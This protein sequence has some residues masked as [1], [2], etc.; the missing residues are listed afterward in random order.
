MINLHTD[1]LGKRYRRRVLFR[2]LSFEVSGG[3]VAAVTGPNGSGKSTLLRI[4]AGVLTPDTGSVAL[5]EGP[6]AVPPDRHSLRVGLVAPYL[7]LYDTLSARENLR[8]IA[9]VRGLNGAETRITEMLHLVNLENRSDDLLGT[10]SSGM[11]QRMKYAA[12]LLASPLLLLLDEPSAN[13][14]EAG[15][16]MVSRVID[17]QI[18]LSR[19]VIVATNDPA[20]AARAA[21]RIDLTRFVV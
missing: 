4:L 16:H 2:D 13:L 6:V 14:D 12:A 19:P 11:K 18:E 8:F 21:R 9:R 5:R 10:F 15:L 17:Y 1:N 20:E 3:E 7:N